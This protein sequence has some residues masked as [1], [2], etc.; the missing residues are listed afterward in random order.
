MKLIHA[1]AALGLISLAACSAPQSAPASDDMLAALSQY[2]GQ[3]F[4][5]AVTSDDPRDADWASE[6]LTIHF[7]QCSDDEV[8]IPLHV[9]ENRSRT[10]IISRQG[11]GLRLQHDHRHEDGSDDAVTMYGGSTVTPPANGRAQFPADQ[12]SKDLFEREGLAVSV[13][14]VWTIALTDTALTYALDRPERHFEVSFD[15]TRPVDVPP[16]PWG[17]E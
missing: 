15:M 9:G 14:N 5:G 7:R 13:T 8:R 16:A 2:C 3:A 4:E 12:F 11:D 1:S 10:W 6:V 17:F